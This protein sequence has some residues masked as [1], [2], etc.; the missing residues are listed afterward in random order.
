MKDRFQ[1]SASMG[2][3]G[4]VVTGGS[5]GTTTVIRG[6]HRSAEWH[7]EVLAWVVLSARKAEAKWH[8]SW[9]AVTQRPEEH[10]G[11]GA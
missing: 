4:N 3:R 10:E 6:E 9:S 8:C 5:H 1:S 11:K 7:A 2:W